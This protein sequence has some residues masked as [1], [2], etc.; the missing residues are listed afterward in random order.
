M[1]AMH[2][3]VWWGM[4]LL[5]RNTRQG[6][7]N[8]P[9]NKD[10]AKRI[11]NGQVVQDLPF[12]EF[13]GVMIPLFTVI[14]ATSYF[15]GPCGLTVH[16]HYTRYIISSYGI[17][18]CPVTYW[19]LFNEAGTV[20]FTDTIVG[21]TGSANY[22]DEYLEK[23]K[24][25]RYDGK[26][27]L[28]NTRSCGEI[29]TS[30]LTDDPGR[31]PCPTTLWKYE[32]KEGEKSFEELSKLDVPLED[33]ALHIDGYWVKDGWRK[34][35]E[36]QLGRKLTD[37]EWK[38]LRYKIIYVVATRDKVILDFEITNINPSYL[39]L[40]PLLNRIKHRFSEKQIKKVVS[41]EDGAIID[42]VNRILPNAVHSFCVFHQ[43]KNVTKK[44]LDEFKEIDLIPDL[45]KEIYELSQELIMSDNAIQS[46]ILLQKIKGIAESRRLSKASKD[47]VRYI[48][49]IYH[50]N[51]VLLE[52]GFV[53]ETNNVM[54]QLFS[55]IDDIVYQARSF[56]QKYSMKNFFSNLFLLFNH[57]AFNTGTWR[58]ISPLERARLR[59]G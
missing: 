42:A 49:E 13:N 53:P 23:Q 34:F 51:R 35:I 29:Y 1:A 28:W 20:Y 38:K 52:K 2:A 10:I 44:Y 14:P 40:V 12:V 50:K 48:V 24:W 30:G 59:P 22:S 3:V 33:G 7:G 21:V 8:I 54:E 16:D 41:D 58:G 46:T 26:C 25:V 9:I 17:I 11:E 31:A 55:L 39:E 56:K 6:K 32:Q 57:R 19:K 43:L 5:N 15:N 4:T 36:L 27:S 45:D 37:R 47:V 18:E